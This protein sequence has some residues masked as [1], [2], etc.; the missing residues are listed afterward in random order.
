[1]VAA[2]IPPI[3]TNVNASIK[4]NV[5]VKFFIIKQCLLI[6]RKW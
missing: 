6:L 1:L 5:L 2:F 3:N 4:M